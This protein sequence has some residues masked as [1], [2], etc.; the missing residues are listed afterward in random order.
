MTMQEIQDEGAKRALRDL[1]LSIQNI[2]P[3]EVIPF[4]STLCVLCFH[5]LRAGGKE[6]EFVR[7][8][9]DAALKDLETPPAFNMK[10]LRIN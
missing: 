1:L 10:D 5:L 2:P 9:L 6:D 7:G 8:M 3:V 4:M